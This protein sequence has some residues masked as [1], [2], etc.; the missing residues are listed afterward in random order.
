MLA[1]RR[2]LAQAGLLMVGGLFL[3]VAAA[4]VGVAGWM[5][6][7]EQSDPIL[8]SL[9]IAAGFALTAG[10]LFLFARPRRRRPPAPAPEASDREAAV[11]A[12]L[13]EAGLGVPPRGQ[14]PA[15]IEAFLFG[16]TAAM[17]LRRGR[18]D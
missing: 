3:V 18:P 12:F 15:L 5:W 9:I 13:H 1:W 7:A 2:A 8:A 14:R 17:R 6:L 10:V 11:R 16:L 4:L